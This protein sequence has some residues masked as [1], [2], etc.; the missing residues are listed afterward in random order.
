[1]LTREPVKAVFFDKD[2][3]LVEDV[4]YNVDPARLSLAPGI[5][6]AL[7]C[8]QDAGYRLVVVSNQSGIARGYFSEE[9]L[10]RLEYV[11][12]QR[13]EILGVSLQGF[14]YCPHH[15]QGTVPAY[16]RRCSCRKPEPGLLLRSA[17]EHNID[18]RRSWLVGDILDDV[19]A[20]RRA[21]C[22]TILLD[23]GNETEWFLSRERLPHH[24]AAN[25]AM[26]QAIISAVDAGTCYE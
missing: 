18:L 4:P 1:M 5:G 20:G 19:Q 17:R 2:G 6:A 15:P 22:R 23:N 8:L 11:L 25:I 10:A 3:T 14:Y 21:G 13:L 12:R 24:L 7:R 26:V 9:A 16:T